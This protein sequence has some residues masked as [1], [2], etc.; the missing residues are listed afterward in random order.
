MEYRHTQIG[1][2]IIVSMVAAIVLV[3]APFWSLGTF[4]PVQIAVLAILVV[5]LALFYSL[6]VEIKDKTLTC[7]LG[8]GLIRKKIPLSEIHQAR[9]VEN[10]WYAGWGI[11]WL[12]GQYCMWNV[13]GLRAVELTLKDGKRF[14]L[15]TDEPEVLIAAI[16]RNKA[17][18]A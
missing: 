13:S 1:V 5:A 14:R 6:S 12:P 2:V 7:R 16:E 15:G 18:R 3:L 8:A 4:H 17:M 10:P 11:R 9:A